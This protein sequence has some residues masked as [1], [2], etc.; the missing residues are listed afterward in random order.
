[1]TRKATNYNL[2]VG[3]K[4]NEIVFLQ[5]SFEYPDM[6]G[7]T[8]FCLSPL[9]QDELDRCNDPETIAEEYGFLWRECVQCGTTE[10][11]LDE[12]VAEFI[13]ESNM[14]GYDYP[15]QDNS[16]I[17]HMTDEIKEKYFPD[18]AAFTCTGG[19][20]CFSK[21]M[22]FDILINPELIEVINQFEN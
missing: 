2:P 3:I 22:E 11:G 13:E 19:G 7:C 14:H 9:S 20:R 15:G 17:E 1:M 18:A 21:N 10:L 16:Y 8:G 4:D 12:W 6:K 5:D